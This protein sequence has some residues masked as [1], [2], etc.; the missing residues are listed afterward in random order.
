MVA[1]DQYGNGHPV[2]YSL[3]ET[4]SNWHMAKCMDHFKRA[5]EHWRFVRIVI[6]DKDMREIDIIRKKLPE[7]RVL[8][9]HFHVIKWLHETIQKSKKTPE[10]YTS[11]RDEFKSLTHREDRTELWDYFDKN[12][13]E[14]C[15]MWVMVYRVGLPHFG[16]HTNNRVESLFGKLK[17][18]LKGH[19]TMRASLKVLLA[20]QRRKEEEYKAKVEMPGTLRDVSYCAWH[21]DTVGSSGDQ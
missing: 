16:N 15:E 13:D 8:L 21:D 14:C 3:I 12:W 2:Q 5:N 11:H 9:C 20:Y 18:Y 1:M 7:A 17:R 19:L 10:A 4:N 6:V